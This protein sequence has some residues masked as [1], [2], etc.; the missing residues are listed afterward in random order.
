MIPVWLT[1]I[2]TIRLSLVFITFLVFICFNTLFHFFFFYFFFF[3][4]LF[5]LSILFLFIFLFPFFLNLLVFILWFFLFLHI[6]FLAFFITCLFLWLFSFKF[7]LLF[8]LFTFG[9][10]FFLVISSNFDPLNFTLM[11]IS[12]IPFHPHL[13]LI[14]NRLRFD[15]TS[16][17]LATF[18]SN[19]NTP[20]NFP[21]HLLFLL[22]L[23]LFLEIILLI[24]EVSLFRFLHWI[25]INF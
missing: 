22:I 7:Q 16:F 3:F 11:Q 6:F 10:A 1:T 9:T 23:I 18:I 19:K 8:L 17:S 13:Y 5:C 20:M 21:L 14:W 12:N 24:S 4:F 25:W 15:S 2:F